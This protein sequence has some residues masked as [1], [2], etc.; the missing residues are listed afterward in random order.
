MHRSIMLVL[1]KLLQRLQMPQGQAAV[2]EGHQ[3]GLVAGVQTDALYRESC[4]HQDLQ[5]L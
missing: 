5:Q 1:V 2:R 4:L 3:E